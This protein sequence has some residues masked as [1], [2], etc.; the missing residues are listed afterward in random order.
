MCYTWGVLFVNFDTTPV[1]HDLI[2][3]VFYFLLFMR[4]GFIWYERLPRVNA[5]YVKMWF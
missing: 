4:G 3:I 2:F 1:Q 5:L